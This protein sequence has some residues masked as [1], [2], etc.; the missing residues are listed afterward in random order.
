[1]ILFVGVQSK[2]QASHGL[3]IDSRSRSSRNLFETVRW[4]TDQAY[5]YHHRNP[6]SAAR[7][8]E[9]AVSSYPVC[10]SAHE[11]DRHVV[12]KTECDWLPV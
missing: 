1:M 6:N 9:A 2:G 12:V 11:T 10:T 4:E 5:S 7:A 8:H 3:L